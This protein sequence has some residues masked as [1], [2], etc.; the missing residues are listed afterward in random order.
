MTLAKGVLH[1]ALQCIA[2]QIWHILLPAVHP[3]GKLKMWEA[4]KHF[5]LARISLAPDNTKR[6]MIIGCRGFSGVSITFVN[7]DLSFTPSPVR[8]MFS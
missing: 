7:P 3:C 5:Y 2:V 1:T 6:E 8:A 4:Y